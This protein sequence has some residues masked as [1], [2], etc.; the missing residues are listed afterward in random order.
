MITEIRLIK[1][2]FQFKREFTY[3]RTFVEF[4]KKENIKIIID[5][6]ADHKMHQGTVSGL[7]KYAVW[8]IFF[9]NSET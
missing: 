3:M 7:L 2:W 9:E 8:G 6:K 1:N 5:K 4:K